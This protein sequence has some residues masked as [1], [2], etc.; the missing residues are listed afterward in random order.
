MVTITVIDLNEAPQAVGELEDIEDA[1]SGGSLSVPDIFLEELFSDEDDTDTIFTYMVDGP[2]SWNLVLKVESVTHTVTAPTVNDAE[3]VY[4][5]PMEEEE[6]EMGNGNGNGNGM[7][8]EEE[9]EPTA[10]PIVQVTITD[11]DID[12]ALGRGDEHT[13]AVNDERF[14]IDEDGMLS[15]KAGEVLEEDTTVMVA[16]TDRYGLTGTGTVTITIAMEEEEGMEDGMDMEDGMGMDDGDGME[17]EMPDP[18]TKEVLFITGDVTGNYGEAGDLGT[19]TIAVVATDDDEI[20]ASGRAEFEVVV[21]D[22][23]DV[24]TAINLANPGGTDNIYYA[25]TVDEND[26]S[27]VPLGTLSVEDLDLEF[28]GPGHPNAQHEWSTDNDKF[29]VTDSGVLML[30]ADEFLDYEGDGAVVTV[31]VTVVDGGGAKKSQEVRVNVTNKNDAPE[32]ADEIGGW[33]VTVDDDLRADDITEGQVI[34]FYLE[35]EADMDANPAFTDEDHMDS[36]TYELVGAPIW[37]Q[38]D[39]DSGHITNVA[40][41]LPEAGNYMITVRATDGGE[42]R[43]EMDA[44]GDP[45]NTDGASAEVTFML[46][47]VVSDDGENFEPDVSVELVNRGDYDEGTGAQLVARVTVEDEDFLVAPHP[48]GVLVGGVPTLDNSDF[49]LSEEYTESADGTSRTWEVWTKAMNSLDHEGLEDVE[50]TVTATDGGGADGSDVINIDVEDSN[51]APE[52]DAEMLTDHDDNGATTTSGL[53]VG[54]VTVEQESATTVTLYLNLYEM[55]SDPDGGDDVDELDFTAESETPWI[56]VHDPALW[57]D[58]KYGADGLEDDAN[59]VDQADDDINWPGNQPDDDD[60]VVI[61]EIDRTAETGDTGQSEDGAIMFTATDEG[62][63]TGEGMIEVAVTDED[64]NIPE[65]ATAVTINGTPREGNGLTMNFDHT[66][67]PDYANGGEPVLVVYTWSAV[68]VDDQGMEGAVE[69][70]QTSTSPTVLILTQEHVGMKIR[71]SVEYYEQDAD[72]GIQAAAEGGT[73]TTMDVVDNVQDAGTANIVLVTTG[74]M[75]MAE[76]DIDEPDGYDDTMVAYTWESSVNGASGWTAVAGD[77]TDDL[78][79]DLG[80]DGGGGN[81]FRLVV[82]Y[83]DNDGVDERIVSGKEKVGALAA[84]DVP[85][86]TGSLNAGGTLMVA[87]GGGS[88]QWQKMTDG[89]WVDIAGATGDLTLTDYHAGMTLRALVTHTDGGNVTAI[90][91]TGDQLIAVSNT[92]PVATGTADEIT[93]TV[94]DPDEG[95]EITR[96]DATVDLNSLFQDAEGDT[97]TY[98]IGIPGG[99]THNTLSNGEYVYVDVDSSTGTAEITYITDDSHGQGANGVLTFTVTADDDNGGTATQ[100]IIIRLNVAPT[101]LS[102]TDSGSRGEDDDTEQGLG[103]LTVVDQNNSDQEFGQYDW[104]VSDD[105]FE[106]T[107]SETDSK[108][109]ELTVKA[110]AVFAVSG[111]ITPI[112]PIPLMSSLLLRTRQAVIRLST[113]SRSRSRTATTRSPTRR[114]MLIRTQCPA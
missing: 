12:A 24:P 56:T 87:A 2:E 99:L 3:F 112:T 7:E 100:D 62:V 94:P 67:D 89:G 58:I 21:D 104:T 8:E 78:T 43:D 93:A 54:G 38:I 97:L 29:V 53:T 16:V 23:N 22:G 77:A 17:E 48:F 15:L 45:V 40:E 84:E 27:G 113:S 52:F 101:D 88:V 108:Q 20:G 61:V 44:D 64:L 18:D 13:Y 86:V 11:P 39:E 9:A 42:D 14:E 10:T 102:G 50:V 28:P 30:M 65:D 70:L 80:A 107:V 111:P 72:G 75:L 51:E 74:T 95:A 37:L 79:V 76:V 66:K 105:R 68:T 73:A 81:Y 4:T 47:V 1:L 109:A 57:E 26:D 92:A 91:A 31:N 83:T 19:Y 110:G 98:A 33:W 63:K 71:A 69:V 41:M 85:T 82:T 46:S 34:S 35:S 60:M 36:L 5:P 96:I 106:I 55:W 32:A 49:E 90:V 25:V 103:T 6:E 114:L 59:E